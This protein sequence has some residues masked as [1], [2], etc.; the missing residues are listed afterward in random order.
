[1]AAHRRDIIFLIALG[2]FFFG[3]QLLLLLPASHSAAW[4]NFDV[5]DSALYSL[6]ADH[7]ADRGLTQDSTNLPEYARARMP[8]YPL[9]LLALRSVSIATGVPEGALATF[10]NFGL[11]IAAS[12]LIYITMIRALADRRI[13]RWSAAAIL[14][15]PGLA[16]YVFAHMPEALTLFLWT[17]VAASLT[18]RNRSLGIWLAGLSA[19]L[20]ILTKP[21][22]LMLVPLIP[23]LFSTKESRPSRSLLFVFGLAPLPLLW[24]LRN[25]CLWGTLVLTPNSGAHL[26]D[27]LRTMLRQ[28][29][30]LSVVER[31]P[32]TDAPRD[33]RVP[34]TLEAWKTKFGFEF[35]NLG[36]RA[37]L[38]G[39]LASEEIAADP[40]GYMKLTMVKQPRL[41][42]GVGTQALYSMSFS[43]SASA[44][45]AVASPDWLWRSGWWAYQLAAEL[46][47][48]LGYLLAAV[49]CWKGFRDPKLRPTILLCIA[50]ILIQAA[51]I[52]PF[53]HTRYRFLMTPFFG[54]LAAIGLA[55]L[56]HVSTRLS[57]W[58]TSSHRDPGS[59]SAS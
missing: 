12:L 18:I 27:Y 53:G 50:A 32:L 59:N 6:F 52:G 36:K 26:Y 54:V 46:L 20:A 14:V 45:A 51:V 31:N 8:I 15:A 58:T 19:G 4:T 49:G 43:D 41:Y 25:W 9:M 3:T 22:S 17:A 38:L 16:P 24:V 40:I 30:G 42:V 47:L 37:T 1:M 57:R 7:I 29:Q 2:G 39:S 28:S 33:D 10:V 21:V 55:K 11:I 34:T 35:E 44:T 56:S 48:L 13:A 23:I 5:E